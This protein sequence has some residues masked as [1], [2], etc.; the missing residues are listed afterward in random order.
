MAEDFEN[1]LVGEIAL[2]NGDPENALPIFNTIIARSSLF[3][4]H[5]SLARTYAALGDHKQH[6]DKVDW[7]RNHKGQALAEWSE[8]MF[9]LEISLLDVL[10]ATQ[11][12]DAK[13]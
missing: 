13:L 8:S 12:V 1:L 3:Q 10:E 9:G 4:A 6:D 7:I 11:E 2:A 5:E